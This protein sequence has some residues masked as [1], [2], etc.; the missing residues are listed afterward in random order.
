METI[1]IPFSGI[2]RS[3]DE[4]IS[5]DGQC[6]ELINAR[7][8]NGS[9]EPVGPPILISQLPILNV[10][11]LYYHPI[12]HKNIVITADGKVYSLNQ[13]YTMDEQ[14]SEEL[15]GTAEI[16]FVGN[17]ACFFLESEMKYCIFTGDSY[18]YLGGAPK[19]P[20]IQISQSNTVKNA[21]SSSLYPSNTNRPS[22]DLSQT[23][24]GTA[25]GY[26]DGIISQLNKEG[27]H[28]GPS[29]VRYAFRLSNGDYISHSP[30]IM[31]ENSET[32]SFT[33]Q[34][35]GKTNN[36]QME[37]TQYVSM[38]YSKKSWDERDSP[39]IHEFG[40]LGTN[41]TFS[42]K[43]LD[44][45]L[46][47]N[48]IVSIDVFVAPISWYRKIPIKENGLDTAYQQYVKIP[49]D[50][51]NEII[52][53]AYRFYRVAEFDLAGNCTYQVDD[54]SL[55]NLSVQPL[56][57][58]DQYSNNQYTSATSYVY[59]S[60]L[61][62]ANIKESFFKG[63]EFGYNV[64][65]INSSSTV[66]TTIIT[67]IN[68]PQGEVIVRRNTTLP[69]PYITTYITYPD[70][71]AY[72]MIIIYQHNSKTYR[73]DFELKAHHFLNLAYYQSNRNI[74]R[75]DKDVRFYDKSYINLST[76]KEGSDDIT[77]KNVT[78][79]RD[80]IMKVSSL[81]S[82]FSFPA[83]QTYQTSNTEII[84][85]CSNTNAL[86]QGQ[87]GQHPLYVFTRDGIFAM[88]VGT[89]AVVYATQTPITRDV[90]IN[91]RTIKGIDS[92]VI[93]A[94]ERGLM[95][96]SGSQTASISPD[97]EG[98]LP[99]CI[100]SSPIIRKIA[101][102]ALEDALSIATFRDYLD[103]AEISYNY[104]ENEILVANSNFRYSYV[105]NINSKSWHKILAD[106][107]AFINSYPDCYAIIKN[108]VYQ[109]QNNNRSI[110]RLLILSRP[111]K[112][113]SNSHKRILQTALRG[114][115]KRALSDLYLRGEPVMFRGENLD[116]F[117]DVGMYILGSN[118]AE[119]FT[120]IS[121]KESIVDI[122]DLVTKMNK[123]KAFKFFMVALAGGVRTDV[124]INYMEFVASEAFGNRLR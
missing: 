20:E 71:R 6:M 59:N 81:N 114:I 48:L 5:A 90:C 83:S 70:S 88:E 47:K 33:F 121:G 91:K 68:V 92:A 43:N 16:E 94:S 124:S 8:K 18:C 17:I 89:G 107:S 78:I 67:Q 66:P 41:L 56:L 12:A 51:V 98:F 1:K 40:V 97:L 15:S 112:M 96:I 50:E 93:F 45:E 2:N 119:H 101:N 64:F 72:K 69:Y 39:D 55:D 74:S 108:G 46:W 25:S 10:T 85:M 30:I 84:G 102:I 106:I 117:S 9:V 32:K 115:V 86:S 31:V 3:V 19:L 23:A 11:K 37:F 54:V 75:S 73:Q 77:E 22:I 57:P 87:Y 38:Q 110:S 36:R 80:N 27:Y 103:G 123:T 99:S 62:I 65:T 21:I 60:R 14:L 24:I 116:I 52:P 42:F 95:M 26:Y 4:G 79:V 118:D 34:F 7:I 82:P 53:K 104:Q 28:V 111:I 61:H 113:G 122:R 105:Y 13:D 58:D 76:F 109:L 44:L 100:N 63:Y 29:L 120:L 35:G 49:G